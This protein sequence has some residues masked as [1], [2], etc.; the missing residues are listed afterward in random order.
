MMPMARMTALIRSLEPAIA[1]AG[2]KDRH[3]R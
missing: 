3:E 2:T 1:D